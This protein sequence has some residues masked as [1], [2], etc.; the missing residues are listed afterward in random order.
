[1]SAIVLTRM[2]RGEE[3][4]GDDHQPY[5]WWSFSKT[6]IAA[7]VLRMVAQGTLALDSD[8][9]ETGFTARHLLQHQSGLRDY[10]MA[11]GYSTAVADGTT[12]WSEGE[13]W[14]RSRADDLLFTPG[15]GW[16]YSNVGYWLLRRLVQRTTDLPLCDALKM[17]VFDPL[18]LEGPKVAETPADL[19]LTGWGNDDGYDPAWVYHGLVVGSGPD[20]CR[21][22]A[23]ILWSDLLPDYLRREMQTPHALPGTPPG[24]PWA[25]G[26]Y[27]LGLMIGLTAGARSV[28]GHTGQ[29]PNSTTAVYALINDEEAGDYTVSA[30]F[31]RSPNEAAAELAAFS[32]FA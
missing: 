6:V 8:I 17:L 30:A 2:N 29:G 31:A 3:P 27:G 19:H 10:T 16:L 1:M 13:M 32:A 9:G 28:A 22:L 24:R 12:P 20:A 11:P 21:T 7:A 14:E 23:G 26:G 4:V 15:G 18:G 25:E 5:P